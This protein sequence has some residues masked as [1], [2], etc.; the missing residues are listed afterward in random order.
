[1]KYEWGGG[2]QKEEV[3]R[4][5]GGR[6]EKGRRGGLSIPSIPSIFPNASAT[7]SEYR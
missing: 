5:N 1:M 4:Q 3:G 2:M 6:R 7:D